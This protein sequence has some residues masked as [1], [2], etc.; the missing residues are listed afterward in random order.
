[1]EIFEHNSKQ[2][3]RALNKI[4][5]I[6]ELIIYEKSEFFLIDEIKY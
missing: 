2:L 6:Q 4:F 1:M 5:Y 3:A